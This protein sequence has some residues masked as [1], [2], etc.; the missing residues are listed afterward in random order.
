MANKFRKKPFL[1]Y[2]TIAYLVDSTQATG[3]NPFLAGQKSA[4]KRERSPSLGSYNYNK[5]GY[6]SVNCIISLNN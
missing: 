5:V 3:T 1:L 6:L 4:F 2:D